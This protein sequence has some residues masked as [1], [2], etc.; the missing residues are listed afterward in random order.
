M[1]SIVCKVINE[2]GIHAR[3][4]SVLT[5]EASDFV[6]DI[7]IVKGDVIADGKSIIN[8][9]SMGLKKGDEVTIE[10]EG[11]DEKT[12]LEHIKKLFENKFGDA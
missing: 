7:K 3:P 1:V 9:L 5:K 11:V 6:S 12:A 10:A 2:T 4:A 8:I